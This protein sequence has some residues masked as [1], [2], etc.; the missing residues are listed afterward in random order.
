MSFVIV[1]SAY[2]VR[3]IFE[4]IFEYKF[5]LIHDGIDKFTNI[6]EINAKGYHIEVQI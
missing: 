3:G 4:K 2:R 5:V 1:F 6:I